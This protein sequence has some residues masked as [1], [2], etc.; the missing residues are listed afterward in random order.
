MKMGGL[1]MLA[2][3]VVMFMAQ[4]VVADLPVHC[5]HHV[6]VGAWKFAMVCASLNLTEFYSISQDASCILPP[7]L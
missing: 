5:P 1:A 3:I 6:H 2:A 4:A 7:S